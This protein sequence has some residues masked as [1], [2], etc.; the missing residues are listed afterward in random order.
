M[1]QAMNAESVLTNADLG[2]EGREPGG[3]K[4]VSILVT[5]S[6]F[7]CHLLRVAASHTK[8]RDGFLLLIWSPMGTILSRWTWNTS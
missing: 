8:M 5:K 4:T 2:I 3:V 1:N 6:V 7:G